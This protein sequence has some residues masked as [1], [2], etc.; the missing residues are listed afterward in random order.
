MENNE[1]FKFELHHEALHPAVAETLV[2][3][4]KNL[5]ELRTYM[6]ALNKQYK[7]VHGVESSAA[8]NIANA[9]TTIRKTLYDDMVTFIQITAESI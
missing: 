8:L 7:S 6:I 2:K 5:D 4:A 1:L 3:H 9:C